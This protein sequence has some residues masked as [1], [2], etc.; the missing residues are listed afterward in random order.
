MADRRDT[1]VWRRKHLG[2][3]QEEMREKEAGSAGKPN[4]WEEVEI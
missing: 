4:L 2:R 1:I 3:A